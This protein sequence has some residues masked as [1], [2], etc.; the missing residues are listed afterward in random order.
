MAELTLP[1]NSKVQK[2]LHFPAPAGAKRVRTFKIYRWTPDDSENPRLDTYDVDLDRCGPMVLDALIKIKNEVDPTLTFRRS[3]REG[4]CG[5]CAM[6]ID[7][8]NTL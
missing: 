7:G 5:S 3:C 8:S 6:N 4:I 1:K 2:G